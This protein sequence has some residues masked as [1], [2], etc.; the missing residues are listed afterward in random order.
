MIKP[1]MEMVNLGLRTEYSFKSELTYGKL[2]RVLDF[3]NGHSAIG[4]ADVNG[5]YGFIRFE[6]LA[7][8]RGIKP[9]FGVRLKVIKDELVRDRSAQ[10]PMYTFIAKNLA[11]YQEINTLVS[12]AFERFYYKAFITISDMVAIT[13]NVFVIAEHVETLERLD[14]IALT[15]TTPPMMLD[16]DIPKVAMNNNSYPTALDKPTYEVFCGAR[17]HGDSF[18]FLYNNQTYPMHILTTSEWYRIWRDDDAILNTHLIADQCSVEIPSAKSV[19]FP[20]KVDIRKLAEQGAAKLGVDLSDPA[21]GE[22]LDKEL[23]I[24]K[25]KDFT[26]YFLVVAD[27]INYAKG[28]MLV[29]PSRGSCAGSL[30]CYLLGI[31][32]IDPII[33]G[34]VFERFIDSNRNDMPDIDIDFPDSK[35]DDVIVYL[36]KKYGHENVT[37]LANINKLKPRSAIGNTAMSLSINYTD[38]EQIKEA[39]VDRSSGDARAAMAVRDTFESTEIGKAFLEKYP[40]IELAFDLEGHATHAGMHAGG[41][42]VCNDE[43]TK[44][45][46]VNVR[47]ECAM[48]D[49]KDA[50]AKNLLKIDVL[51]LRTLSVLETACNMAGFD[52]QLLYKMPTDYEPAFDI[53]NEMRLS[54]IFQ[55]EGQA[56]MMLCKE[57]GVHK[58]DD[59]VALT[60]LAR[61]GPL[62]SGGANAFIARRTGSVPVEY[63]SD[64]PIYVQ[65]TSETYGVIVYQEQLMNICRKLGQMAWNDVQSIRRAASKSM[66]A[67][68]FNTYKEKFLTGAKD[69][70]VNEDEATQIWENMVTFGSWGMNKSHTVAYGFI[71]YWCA[72]MKKKYPLAFAAANLR[73]SKGPDSALKMLRDMKEND[74]IDYI[75]YDPEASE[76]DW[77][78]VGDKLVGGLINIEGIGEKKAKA[79][80]DKRKSGQKMTMTEV[81]KLYNGETPFDILY[82]AR[83]WWGDLYENYAAYGLPKPPTDIKEIEE[84]GQY[85][86]VG[87]IKVKDVRDL[88]EYNEVMKRGGEVLESNS[89]FLRLVVEDDTGQ[90]LT[91]INRYKFDAMHGAQLAEELKIGKSW[92]LIKGQLKDFGWR[93]IE[94]DAIVD[95]EKISYTGEHKYAS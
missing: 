70:G 90:I 25:E 54:G 93:V 45:C 47:D 12:K 57:M 69:N 76:V 80:V 87:R 28:F 7:K 1:K 42:L 79:L 71:S 56:M 78:I 52:P 11:G 27:M 94:I 91:K 62:H 74:G 9:I 43:L 92:V 22:R 83:H 21:Y 53:F 68:F 6:K 3:H 38:T 31:T 73:H 5:T 2:D 64:H 13:D 50:E 77:S 88:N 39:I 15:T 26:D 82:P 75:P 59:I 95:L 86:I 18:R 85:Y 32:T 29:G 49:K 66:G 37:H 19:R 40:A 89:R 16:F 72:F 60:A 35:R 61:P 17:K 84:P 65:E 4:V 23:G 14:Y 63:I 51:G 10:G 30:T 67:D 81:K 24:I 44:Y 55:F 33:H 48:I 34:L 36:M 8:E 20:G 41:I 58:F 46:G